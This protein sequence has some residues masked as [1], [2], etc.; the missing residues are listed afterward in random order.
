MMSSALPPEKRP[1]L[2]FDELRFADGTVQRQARLFQDLA[3]K[4][5]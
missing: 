2:K 4:T 1:I 5:D 3:E